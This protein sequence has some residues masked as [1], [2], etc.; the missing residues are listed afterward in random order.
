[1][2]SK[3]KIKKQGHTELQH[4]IVGALATAGTSAANG[5]TVQITFAN[6]LVSSTTGVQQF[7]GDL[8]GDSTYNPEVAGI[9]AA[10]APPQGNGGYAIPGIDMRASVKTLGYQ[11]A[12]VADVRGGNNPI[13]IVGNVGLGAYDGAVGTTRALATIKFTDSR[14]NG[15]AETNGWLDMSAT[16]SS[17][18]ASVQIH[19]LIFDDAST[20]APTG[21]S[22]SSS[23]IAEWNAVPEPS[24]LALLALGAGGL[25]IRRR[26]AG[27][28]AA[29]RGE[30]PV[31]WI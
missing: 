27:Y 8:T 14:I 17:N 12:V 24:S 18:E 13:R 7:T 20:S 4:F 5:A 3:I 19:R 23:G 31:S 15:G 28:I 29:H 2:E 30:W 25:L 16:L 10:A 11:V 9:W 21:L 1:M 26:R 22:S 6:N